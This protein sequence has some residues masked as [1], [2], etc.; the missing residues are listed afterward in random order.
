MRDHISKFCLSYARESITAR[1]TE[2]ALLADHLMCI[3]IRAR[4]VETLAPNRRTE[5]LLQ[6]LATVQI[7]ARKLSQNSHRSPSERLGGIAA[8][9]IDRS[10]DQIFADFEAE[11]LTL[12]QS[13]NLDFN[14]PVLRQSKRDSGPR[15]SVRLI[16][17]RPNT[18]FQ[19]HPTLQVHLIRATEILSENGANKPFQALTDFLQQAKT[20]FPTLKIQIA[21]DSRSL[22][23]LVERANRSNFII[24]KIRREPDKTV[25]RKLMDT[26]IELIDPEPV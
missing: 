17:G 8:G 5:Q 9:I 14:R 15:A 3:L 22:K 16:V 19:F 6:T 10:I 2:V 23:R 18:R 26:L 11:A 24:E 1:N 21:S 20:K 4:K 25:Q 13:E 7:K 12:I